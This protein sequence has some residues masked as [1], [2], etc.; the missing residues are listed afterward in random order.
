MFSVLA[1]S[2]FIYIYALV[3]KR[4]S[5]VYAAFLFCVLALSYFLY[6]YNMGHWFPSEFDFVELNAIVE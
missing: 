2:Y 1:L 3:S 5:F 4:V 6:I